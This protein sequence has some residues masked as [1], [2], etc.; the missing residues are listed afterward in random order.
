MVTFNTLYLVPY[1]LSFMLSFALAIYAFR[2]ESVAGAKLFAWF[3]LSEA[4][5]TQGYILELISP[6][7]SQKI[8]WDMVQWLPALLSAIFAFYCALYYTLRRPHPYFIWVYLFP[9]I[10]MVAMLLNPAPFY[11]QA[12]IIDSPPFDMLY[13]ELSGIVAVTF[14]FMYGLG[15]IS[16]MMLIYH[17]RQQKGILRLQA[18]VVTMGI[19]IVVFSGIV[20]NLFDLTI[21]GQ[22]DTTPFTMLAGNI[23]IA[24]GIFRYRLFNPIPVGQKL[25]LDSISDAV[26]IVDNNERVLHLNAPALEVVTLKNYVGYSVEEVFPDWKAEIDR[27]RQLVKAEVETRTTINGKTEYYDLRVVPIVDRRGKI[28]GRL[29]MSRNITQQRELADLQANHARLQ[30]ELGKEQELS[31]LKNAMMVRI[32]H[33]FRTPLAVIQTSATLI[34]KYGE[35]LSSEQR[36]TKSETIY[37]QIERI[38][39]MLNEISLIMNN[40]IAP[41]Q[42]KLEALHLEL[43]CQAEILSAQSAFKTNHL[44]HVQCSQ[45]I[46]IQGDFLLISKAIFNLI[47]NAVNYAT[48]DSPIQIMLDIQADFASMTLVNIGLGVLDSEQ[49]RIFQPFFR[50]SNIGEVG[51]LGLGL[52]VANTIVKAHGGNITLTNPSPQKT[53]FVLKLPLQPTLVT[54]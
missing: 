41:S 17:I 19:S 12:Q 24:L 10:F 47:A 30:Y 21:L 45:P 25:F 14:V 22:R 20:V 40:H 34:D 4:L 1:F 51:G 37:R 13:Y 15:I 38:I 43:L 49:E 50:G 31:D 8:F 44:F 9:L 36:K 6:T 32:G 42:L 52:T 53:T 16:V 46:S 23:M 7:L 3:A 5:W 18:I 28:Q 29:V 11:V 27:F 33:E 2:R 35:R 26:V 39:S 48:P 54:H